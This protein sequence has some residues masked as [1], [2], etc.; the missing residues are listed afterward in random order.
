MPQGGRFE[1]IWLRWD[2]KVAI[3]VPCCPVQAGV[4]T[5]RIAVIPH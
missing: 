1:V 5:I 2:S 3:L 4:D